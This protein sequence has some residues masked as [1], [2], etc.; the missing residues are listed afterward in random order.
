MRVWYIQDARGT[1]GH[2]RCL[3]HIW[4]IMDKV[5][6]VRW[7]LVP[8]R[9]GSSSIP[10]FWATLDYLAILNTIPS[11]SRQYCRWGTVKYCTNTLRNCTRSVDGGR[12]ICAQIEWESPP[13]STTEL[14]TAAVEMVTMRMVMVMRMM[15]MAIRMTMMR[16]NDGDH[17]QP[18]T[19]TQ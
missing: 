6:G 7:Y 4:V 16:K 3:R 13:V 2:M 8:K 9:L 15:M 12:T 10:V 17:Y 19:K 14:H 18:L 11:L 5:W 1:Y